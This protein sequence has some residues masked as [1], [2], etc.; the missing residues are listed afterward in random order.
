[1]PTPRPAPPAGRVDAI[2]IGASAGGVDALP[3]LQPALPTNFRPAVLVVL[4]LPRGLP[5]LPPEMF[6]T[7]CTLPVHAARDK[8]PIQLGKLYF[9]P[10]NH[11]LLVDLDAKGPLLALST[12]APVHFSRPA[13][14][15]LFESA[16][17]V[18]GARLGGVILSGANADGALGLQ[19]VKRR[20]GVTLVQAP[21]TARSPTML[22]AALAAGPVDFVLPLEQMPAVFRAWGDDGAI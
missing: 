2:V 12:D 10:P 20:G 15:V 6:A 9:A 17:A 21:E 13:I 4:H 19:A 7:R 1:M 11:H 8:Q 16:A 5:S 14:D 3:H 18:Y 22:Q